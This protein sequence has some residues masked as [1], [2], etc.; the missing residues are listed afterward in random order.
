[1]LA[2]SM[3]CMFQYMLISLSPDFGLCECS[4][5]IFAN[6]VHL[7]CLRF[8]ASGLCQTT[9]AILS[10]FDIKLSTSL[11]TM[12]MH[13]LTISLFHLIYLKIFY[14]SYFSYQILENMPVEM[15]GYGFSSVSFYYS[16]AHYCTFSCH[17]CT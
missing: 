16:L 17:H 14:S 15:N 3:S 2:Q 1:M 8:N 13:A 12:M 11:E 6:A 7:A 5:C 10:F 4:S 9:L